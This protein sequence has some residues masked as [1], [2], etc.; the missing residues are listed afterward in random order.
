VI[1]G[2]VAIIEHAICGH[3]WTV[4]PIIQGDTIVRPAVVH[5]CSDGERHAMEHRCNCGA[6]D[7]S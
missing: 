1:F 2:A 3:R 6:V 7:P 4:P 5:V